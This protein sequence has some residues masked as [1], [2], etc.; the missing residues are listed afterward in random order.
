MK[1]EVFHMKRVLIL[2]GA[3]ALSLGASLVGAKEAL[4][5]KADLKDDLQALLLKYKDANGRYTKKTSMHLSDTSSAEVISHF[6]A[7]AITQ[8][9]ATYYDETKGALLMGDYAGGFTTINGGYRNIPDTNNSQRF[10]HK[11]EVSDIFS[12]AEMEDDYVATGLKVGE[13]FPT[14]TSLSNI[15]NA[16]DWTESAGVYKHEITD[17]S[18]VD[19]QYVDQI[20]AKFQY[21]AAPM[22]LQ[23]NYISFK[24]IVVKEEASSLKIELQVSPSDTGKIV[25]NGI[26]FSDAVITSGI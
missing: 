23:C 21:F 3:L 7:G 12:E 13:Y 18:V 5:A 20:L 19:G 25:D 17:M 22:F 10:H 11:G 6:H 26:T 8:Q 9:R 15:I 16:A 14:L 1:L 24:Y 4:S 2:V